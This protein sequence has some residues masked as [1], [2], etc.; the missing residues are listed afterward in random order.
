MSEE[1]FVEDYTWVRG[2]PRR[3]TRRVELP[4]PCCIVVH[5]IE[6]PVEQ[7]REIPPFYRMTDTSYLRRMCEF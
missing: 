6:T 7:K 4:E 1:Y 5:K 3:I 2:H